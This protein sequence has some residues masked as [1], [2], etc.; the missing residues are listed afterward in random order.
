MKP[1][2]SDPFY[3]EENQDFLKK[4]LAE[5][6]PQSSKDKV[7]QS[8]DVADFIK[9]VGDYVHNVSKSSRRI[10]V[11][12]DDNRKVVLLSQN[13]YDDLIEKIYLLEKTRE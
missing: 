5:M 11:T 3:S 13:D 10:T 4:S 9:N 1:G 2:N 6:E 7:M 12:G 8:V